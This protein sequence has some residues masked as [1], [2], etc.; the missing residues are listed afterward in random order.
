MKKL[1]HLSLGLACVSACAETEE[2][3]G[4]LVHEDG[5]R[6]SWTSSIVD[7]TRAQA[8]LGRDPGGRLAL[9]RLDDGE[10]VTRFSLGAL[11]GVPD[12]SAFVRDDGSLSHLALLA[13]DAEEQGGRLR[14][15]SASPEGFARPVSVA[16]LNGVTRTL[17][18]E[19]GALVMQDDLGERWSFAQKDGVFATTTACPKPASILAH[20][21]SPSHAAVLAF[22]W[23]AE[24][25][26]VLVDATLTNAEWRCDVFPLTGAGSLS[27]SA[28]AALVPELGAVIVDGDPSGLRVALAGGSE[29]GPFVSSDLRALRVEQVEPFRLEGR[30]GVVV[31]TSRPAAVTALTLERGVGGELTIAESVSVLL[32]FVVESPWFSREL[33]LTHDRLF[34]ATDGGLVGFALMLAPTLDLEQIA[35]PE[36]LAELR[37]PLVPVPILPVGYLPAVDHDHSRSD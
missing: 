12:A 17:A 6:H 22:A 9:V 30:S 35:L 36:S 4:T 19:G 20:D 2:S 13:H 37:G 11:D 23:S 24:A 1:L 29:V 5:P 14:F 26:P 34:I 8:L 7:S 32:P 27:P 3:I 16:A 15:A 21:S 10:V 31:L 18:L 25:E 28:R 33:A